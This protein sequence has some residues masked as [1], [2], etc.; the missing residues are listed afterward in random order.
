M[1]TLPETEVT[2]GDSFGCILP[3]P[4]SPGSLSDGRTTIKI[5][6]IRPALDSVTALVADGTYGAGRTLSFNASFSEPVYVAQGSEPKLNLDFDGT[7]RNA[8]YARGNGSASLVFG[9]TVQ[10][11]DGDVPPGLQRDQRPAG[12]RKGCRGQPRELDKGGRARRARLAR[13]H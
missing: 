12:R 4:G 3:N 1:P 6:G 13:P 5:D 10:P 7:Y 9:Y 2:G 11:G 8:T